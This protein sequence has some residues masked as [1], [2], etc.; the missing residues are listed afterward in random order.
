[1][2]SVEQK[3]FFQKR[4]IADLSVRAGR[5][6]TLATG[7]IQLCIGSVYS[8]KC[9]YWIAQSKRL[10]IFYDRMQKAFFKR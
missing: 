9:K 10:S 1:M 2:S 6:N 8:L 4:H 7:G 3:F 5:L